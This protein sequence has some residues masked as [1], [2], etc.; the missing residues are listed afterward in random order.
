[1]N[2]TSGPKLTAVFYEFACNNSVILWPEIGID[3]L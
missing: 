3:V 2:V 1:M